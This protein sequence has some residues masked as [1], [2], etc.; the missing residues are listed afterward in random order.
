MAVEVEGTSQV[1]EFLGILRRRAWWIV[2][3]TILFGTLGIAVAVIVP[4]KYVSFARVLVRDV[5]GLIQPSA[6]GSVSRMEGLVA[7]YVVG[8]RERV[9]EVL[10]NL[11]WPEYLDL[12]IPEQAEYGDRL[13]EGLMIG[14]ESAQINMGAQIV[15][16]RFRH[17]QPQRAYDFVNSLVRSWKQGVQTRFQESERS[18]LETLKVGHDRL[19]AERATVSQSLEEK[20]RANRIRPDIEFDQRGTPNFTG[21]QFD[22]LDRIKVTIDETE[23]E[24]AELELS[25]ARF[26]AERDKLPEFDT[27]GPQVATGS[28]VMDDIRSL[29]NER[30]RLLEKMTESGLTVH[31]SAYKLA[32]KRIDA[33]N[34]SLDELRGFTVSGARAPE[35]KVVHPKRVELRQVIEQAQVDLAHLKERQE[36]NIARRTELEGETDRLQRELQDI[37]VL[38]ARFN[39]LST[40]IEEM[41]TKLKLQEAQVAT[42]AGDAGTF[43]ED[44]NTP[45][46]P[47]KPTEPNPI[48]ISVLGIFMGLAIGLGL[49]VLMELSRSTFRNARD[50]SRV[51]V[52]PVLGTVNRIVTRRQRA[53]QLFARTGVAVG[54][55]AFVSVIGYVTWAWVYDTDSLSGPLRSAIEGLR[56]PFL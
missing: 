38:D 56:E 32:K 46:V 4:K 30:Q 28:S 49:A 9:G 18:R 25:I 55:L 5:S 24:I 33:I 6:N 34:Q 2:V 1:E 27:S 41:G 54:M 14:L 48:I 53:R 26:T 39:E 42:I 15:N 23:N 19:E 22:E 47:Q 51:M 31:N 10:A 3:P 45:L 8:S 37:R 36:R 52:V 11:R 21:G 7:P 16:V 20:R 43:F 50:I 12:T 29:E 44:L 35:V 17:T 40:Q 13:S